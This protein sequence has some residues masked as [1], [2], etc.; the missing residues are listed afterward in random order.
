MGEKVVLSILIPYH[1]H[2]GSDRDN[3]RSKA[4]NSGPLN[5]TGTHAAHRKHIH[6]P[7]MQHTSDAFPMEVSSGKDTKLSAG[8]KSCANST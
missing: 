4:S 3:L 8:T 1:S 5:I 2:H 7:S 6:R